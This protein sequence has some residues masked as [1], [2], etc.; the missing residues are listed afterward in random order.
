MLKKYVQ[1][2]A[3]NYVYAIIASLY[4]LLHPR[5]KLRIVYPAGHCWLVRTLDEKYYTFRNMPKRGSKEFQKYKYERYNWDGFCSVESTDL[6]VDIGAFL[7]EFSVPAAHTAKEVIAIEPNPNTHA[8]LMQQM[9]NLENVNII[10]KLPSDKEQTVSF[11]N[12]YDPS[13][14]SILDVDTGEFEEVKLQSQPLDEIMNDLD[15]SY[16]NFLKM[17]AEGAEPEVLHGIQ[18]VTVEKFA[19]DVGAEREG[20]STAREVTNILNKRG[21]EV[22]IKTDKNN[23]PV[24][25]AKLV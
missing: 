18:N 1:S 15:V 14:S 6:V 12:A 11:K 19:I 21:Y 23:D 8:C 25:F 24:V 2:Y 3:P 17:D 10:N 9:K 4:F 16:V 7:G 22:K 5:E 13:E 20:E